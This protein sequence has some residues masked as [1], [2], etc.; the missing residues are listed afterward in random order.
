MCG[1]PPLQRSA[2]EKQRRSKPALTPPPLPSR[3]NEG[4]LGRR[5]G[6]GPCECGRHRSAPAA[7][8]S[9]SRLPRPRAFSSEM[10]TGLR[11]GTRLKQIE[12]EFLRFKEAGKYSSS[13][14]RGF[15]VRRCVMCDARGCDASGRE[16]E[17]Q[18][19]PTQVIG[20]F[21]P[22]PHSGVR[23]M[24]TIPSASMAF[25][26]DCDPV[27]LNER[28]GLGAGP[29]RLCAT[30]PHLPRAHLSP[31]PTSRGRLRLDGSLNCSCEP[32]TILHGRRL[33]P[34]PESAT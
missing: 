31:L 25:R 27:R 10:A 17:A 8:Q 16:G 22:L 30:L 29:A 1:S 19:A 23:L 24:R 9:E 21:R 32:L 13:V 5:D 15:Q 7:F 3:Q 11:E 28:P 33:F 2:T 6:Q 14:A 34:S 4:S 20:H 18:G 12:R 26:W